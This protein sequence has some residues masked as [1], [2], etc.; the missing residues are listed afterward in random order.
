LL[1]RDI[2]GFTLIETLVA[3]LTGVVVTGALFAI[4]EVS[5]SESSRL[6]DRVQADRLG[7]TA[8]TRLV[9]ELHSACLAPG[10]A[11]VLAKSTATELWFV[12]AYSA[13]AVIPYSEAHEHEILWS[14]ATETLTDYEY[15]STAGTWPNFTFS[16]T[17]SPAGGTR[18]ASNVTQTGSTPIF[19]YYKYATASSSGETE[20]RST[21]TALTPP[22]TTTAP[23][24][25]SVLIT[26]TAGSPPDGDTQPSR[27]VELSSQV[28]F[29]FS[30]PASETTIEDS[31]C[32]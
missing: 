18:V 4:L 15:P 25:A 10:F 20:S 14:K 2:R 19:T 26:F 6:S 28:T 13:A 29:A 5:L 32:E 9:D 17:A 27:S 24:A 16:S 1:A 21:L 23:E 22:L 30:A 11:P 7:R 31:P 8:M 12:N 3:I